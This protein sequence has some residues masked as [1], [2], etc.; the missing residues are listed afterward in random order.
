[1]SILLGNA[2]ITHSLWRAQGTAVTILR[3]F[4]SAVVALCSSTLIIGAMKW[5]S[6]AYSGFVKN[7]S[8]NEDIGECLLCAQKIPQCLFPSSMVSGDASAMYHT[9]EEVDRAFADCELA[10][11]AREA[12]AVCN[13]MLCPGCG[14][15]HFS[16]STAVGGN[17]G[18]RVCNDCGVI[19]PGSVIFE[20]MCGRRVPVCSSNY[21]RIHHWHE[22]ISQFL[23]LESTIPPAHML[24]IGERLLDGTHTHVNKDS[25]RAVLR[26]LGLQAYIE[27]WLQIIFRL[28]GVRPPMLGPVMMEKLDTLFIDLQRPFN[29]HKA[30]SRRN[31]LNYNYVFCR[32]LQKMHCESFMV[33]FPLI[34]S[35][36]KLRHL[37][38]MWRPMAESI[39]WEVPELPSVKSFAVQLSD[40]EGRLSK[41]RSQAEYAIQVAPPSAPSKTV[42]RTWSRRPQVPSSERRPPHRSERPEPRPQ[43][44]ASRLKRK[45]LEDH[46]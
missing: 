30:D 20:N 21:K 11:P 44:L 29:A 25:I 12:D 43:S 41:L 37:D 39:G 27:K 1:M 9:Q 16:Y 28:T 17:A 26:S 4:A 34:R 2:H 14:G 24:A 31:F 6:Y 36:P 35:K 15:A 19:A 46:A 33:F 45:R 22:R 40:T 7:T 32:L 42:Y 5:S 8:W 3:P 23:L 13:R 10:L 38:E 18:D